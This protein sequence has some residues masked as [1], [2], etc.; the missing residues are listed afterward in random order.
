MRLITYRAQLEG[1]AG[2]FGACPEVG[3]AVC[4]QPSGSALGVTVSRSWK[5]F[6][7]GKRR[8]KHESLLV[9]GCSSAQMGQ[10][11]L[12]LLPAL[13]GIAALP[14]LHSSAPPGAGQMEV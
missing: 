12:R 14:L 11:G 6:R 4:R 3:E 2:G 13:P 8:Q 1:R 9:G 7:H 5:D 10:V